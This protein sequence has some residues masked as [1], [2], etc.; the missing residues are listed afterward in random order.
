MKILLLTPTPPDHLH[1]I[2]ALQILKALAREHAVSVLTF[3]RNKQDLEKCEAI[4]DYCEAVHWVPFSLP[5]ALINCALALPTPLPLRVAYQRSPA[6]RRKLH[7]LVRNESY[8]LIY[9]KRKRMAQYVWQMKT[10]PRRIL[11]LTDA[12][13]LYYKRSLETV[14]WLRYP[15]HYEEY[16]TIRRYEPKILRYF[17]R[18]V[19]CSQVDADFLENEAGEPLDNLRVIPNVVDTD[20]YRSHASPPDTREPVLLFSGLMDKHVN[21]DAARYLVEE[22]YPTIHEQCPNVR[23]YIVGPRPVPEVRALER[24]P[25]VIVTG[26]VDDLRSYIEK[27]S[28]VLCPVKVGAGTRNKILQAMSMQRSVVSTPLGAEGLAF[29]TDRDLLIASD[30]TDFARQ[31]LRLLNDPDLAATLASRG[32]A[33]VQRCYSIDLL[34]TSLGEL[35]A[36][37]GHR[38]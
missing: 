18:A 17:D 11:D 20:F 2:R 32:R 31:T 1:R 14:D 3:V 29:E 34:A 38:T 9:V 7:E 8:D 10:P 23:L 21:V 35:F 37:I 4:R 36:E 27:A 13:A 24:A 25:G 28:V 12:V 5:R 22:I 33:L 26:Y 6:M 15:I 30:A 16:V 19:V